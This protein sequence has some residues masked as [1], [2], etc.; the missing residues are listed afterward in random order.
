MIVFEGAVFVSRNRQTRLVIISIIV[1]LIFGALGWLWQ[2]EVRHGRYRDLIPAMYTIGFVKLNYY[3]PVNFVKLVNIY[4]KT[5]SIGKALDSL[6][7]PYTQMLSEEDL[8]ELKKETDGYFEGI[9]IYLQKGEPVIWKVVEG[10]PSQ[11]AGLRAG[12]RIIEIDNA[13]VDSVETVI[14]RIK[15]EAGTQVRLKIVRNEKGRPTEYVINIT[16]AKIY[17]PTV[18]MKISDDPVLGKYAYVKI[19]QFADT[20]A[21]DLE[22]NLKILDKRDD[23]KGMILDLRA[24]P[25]GLLDSA[26]DVTGHFLPKGTPVIYIYKRGQ[27]VN[28][29]KTNSQGVHRQMPLV[30][31]VDYWSASAAEIVAGALKDQQRATLVGTP[32]YGKDLIQEIK[33]LP[34]DTAFKITVYNYLT[35]GKK[36]IHKRGVQPNQIVGSSLKKVLRN[37]NMEEYY[38]IQTEQEEAALKILRDQVVKSQSREKLAG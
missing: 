10:T 14:S 16:R 3:Q 33:E 9:G 34:G 21:Q 26:V 29:I 8:A 6:H 4:F 37:N 25:G 20:T 22:K 1:F 5:G 35:S 18:V 27:L 28:I 17:I 24:N 13:K 36:N 30:V 32:T 11:K 15:G 23:C 38:K 2:K 7:D 12:D 19:D 31:L